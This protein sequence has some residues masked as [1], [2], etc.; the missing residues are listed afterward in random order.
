[1]ISVDENLLKL[2]HGMYVV[3]SFSEEK[4]N[5]QIANTVFQ[6]TSKPP[7]IATAINKDNFTHGLIDNSGLFSV[8]ILEKDT[9]MDLI[10][11]F[12][13]NSGGNRNKFEGIDYRKLDNG[14]PVLKKNCLSF[15]VA[16]VFKRI[17]VGTHTIFVGNL[18]KSEKIKEGEPMD[19]SYYRKMKGGATPVTAP[20]FQN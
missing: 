17:D 10:N 18:E 2:S 11:L 16:K 7:R 5:G 13:F 12:G 1:M 4:I 8:C 19:Y 20:T 6:V 9:P 14:L 15:L 3:S